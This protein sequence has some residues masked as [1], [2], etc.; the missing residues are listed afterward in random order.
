MANGEKSKRGAETVQILS[1][2]GLLAQILKKI[3]RYESH[4]SQLMGGTGTISSSIQ[5]TAVLPIDAL[6]GPFNLNE[7]ISRVEERSVLDVG[8]TSEIKDI[9]E[10]IEKLREI[11]EASLKQQESTKTTPIKQ[12]PSENSAEETRVTTIESAKLSG[13]LES[14]MQNQLLGIEMSLKQ[15][16]DKLLKENTEQIKQKIEAE[17]EETRVIQ[18]KISSWNAEDEKADRLKSLR[19]SFLMSSAGKE[20]PSSKL[21]LRPP[22]GGVRR[23]E[24][25]HSSVIPSIPDYPEPP[26]EHSSQYEAGETSSDTEEVHVDELGDK[27][28]KFLATP[29]ISPPKLQHAHNRQRSFDMVSIMSAVKPPKVISLPASTQTM[30]PYLHLESCVGV[31]IRHG[32]LTEKHHDRTNQEP[33]MPHLTVQT[34]IGLQLAPQR[35]FRHPIS[36]QTRQTQTNILKTQIEVSVQ[37]EHAYPWNRRQQYETENFSINPYPNHTDIQVDEMSAGSCENLSPQIEVSKEISTPSE[38]GHPKAPLTQA[39]IDTESSEFSKALTD[40]LRNS[41]I[42]VHLLTK[43]TSGLLTGQTSEIISNYLSAQMESL[44]R[45]KQPVIKIDRQGFLL[46]MYFES[47]RLSKF[48]ANPRKLLGHFLR[49]FRSLQ[50]RC[51]VGDGRQHDVEE[52]DRPRRGAERPGPQVRR[53]RSAPCSSRLPEVD[54]RP[55]QSAQVAA[56]SDQRSFVRRVRCGRTET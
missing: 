19:E 2:D 9:K 1:A 33:K 40:M 49:C 24:R 12:K 37:T 32:T 3:E 55:P 17:L 20:R 47:E 29:L 6:E 18:K 23:L 31:L 27:V 34:L 54:V 15:Q 38:A 13:L 14:T 16:I 51:A 43:V 8:N 36:T 50:V 7:S 41:L 48:V 52:F 42:Y 21:A 26:Y 28:P 10:D 11:L 56:V 45:I 35:R 44:K 4:A 22:Q 39:E 5:G 25:R 46:F 53:S 30:Q